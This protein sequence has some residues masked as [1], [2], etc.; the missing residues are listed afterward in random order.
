[1]ILKNNLE[2]HSLAI[3]Q[4]GNV[5][6]LPYKALIYLTADCIYGGRV[7]DDWDRRTLFSIL[8][9][10]YNDTVIHEDVYMINQLPEYKIEYYETVEE[11]I[12]QFTSLPESQNPEVL[13]LHKNA[14]IRKQMEESSSLL[15]ALSGLDKNESS[16]S[17]GSSKVNI[18]YSIFENVN[19]KLV[20]SFNIEDAKKKY[21]IKYEDCMNSILIQEIMRYNSLLN[22]VFKS[23]NETL[24]AFQGLLPLTDSFEEIAQQ[25]ISNRTPSHWIKSS[26]PSRKPIGSWINDLAD[27]LNFFSNWINTGTPEKFW[28]SAFYFT[29]SFLTGIKQNFAR[30]YKVSIDKLEFNFLYVDNKEIEEES[31][32]SKIKK[33]GYFTYGL[34]IEGARWNSDL[35]CVDELSGKNLNDKLPPIILTV[36]DITINSSKCDIFVDN[37]EK[38]FI[39]Q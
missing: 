28:I 37:K 14:L 8:E 30:K 3:Q 24:Q 25:L 27:R 29:Q 26:Y 9:D 35:H 1:M 12:N 7:T 5:I 10:F 22:L 15:I 18:L 23:I 32:N 4:G 36:K 13:G 38:H 34:Y 2:K 21:P 33:D 16:Q 11:Y 31:T 39:Y 17:S 6:S 20:R 19:K